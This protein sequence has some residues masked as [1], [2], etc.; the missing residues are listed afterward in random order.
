MKEAKEDGVVDD[1][2]VGG[3]G[4]Y[5]VCGEN[6]LFGGEGVQESESVEIVWKEIGRFSKVSRAV[7]RVHE[8]RRSEIDFER[9]VSESGVVF[10]DAI[11]L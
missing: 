9:Q 8:C 4:G 1:L 3:D 2:W 6:G 10:L 11:I 5:G 7:W